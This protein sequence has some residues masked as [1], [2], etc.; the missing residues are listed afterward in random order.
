MA[1]SPEQIEKRRSYIGGSD[2]KTVLEGDGPAWERLRAEKVDG[3]RPEFK[4]AQQLL[5]DMGSAIEPLCLREMNKKVPLQPIASDYH[6]VWKTDPILAFTPDGITYEDKAVVQCKFHTGDQTI[7]DLAESY[8]AQLT[9]EMICADAQRMWLAVI[10]GHYGRFMHM[11]IKRDEALVDQYL[12]KAMEFKEYITTGVLPET[13]V[14]EIVPLKLDRKRDHVWAPGNNEVAPLCES[15]VD[16]MTQ[17]A[18]FTAALDDMKKI[19]KRAEYAD[20]G[21]LTWRNDEGYGVTFKLDA[22]GAVRYHLAF[23]PRTKKA[24]AAAKAARG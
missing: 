23:P 10:F 14:G 8:K 1:L 6:I 5:M 19:I 18:L 9:H 15:L 17:H 22:R 12:M 24:M 11:E 2:A 4:P 21:S 13:M 20:C 16:N 7:L 3:I